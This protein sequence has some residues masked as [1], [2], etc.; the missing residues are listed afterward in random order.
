M[1]RRASQSTRFCAVESS[2]AIFSSSPFGLGGGGGIA[3]SILGLTLVE[4][5]EPKGII[6]LPEGEIGTS[7]KSLQN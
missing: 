4:T 3:I 1:R 2:V 6:C 7:D 5:L